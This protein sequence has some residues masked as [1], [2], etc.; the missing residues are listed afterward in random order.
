MLE[1]IEHTKQ[2]YAELGDDHAAIK[3]KVE[4]DKKLFVGQE[5]KGKKLGVIGLGHI[6]ASV[7]DA[8]IDLG[9]QV[10]GYDP[11]LSVEQAWR[12]PGHEITRCDTIEELLEQSDYVTIHS[13]YM[14][15]THHLLNEKRLKLM[16]PDSHIVNFAR[17]EL[18]DSSAMHSLYQAGKRTGRY[19]CDFP[20]ENL[21]G[22][23]RV[24]IIPHLG[25]STN[26]A[27]DNSAAMIAKQLMDFI[28]TGNVI[29]SVN[30]PQTKLDRPPKSGARICIVNKNVPGILGLITSTLGSANLNIQ[31]HI[32]TSKGEIAY[33]VIDVS[34]MPSVEDATALQSE[35][36]KLEGVVSSRI[37][38][39]SPEPRFFRVRG[40][41]F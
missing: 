25:A 31:Q 3:K 1:G 36:A 22:H 8:A 32:N 10:L 18:I 17:A 26:E 2:I 16:K 15:A 19:I 41:G 5:V 38:E 39:P 35:I 9:M 11:G 4:S 20:D 40:D 30:F 24:T 12:L 28:E 37:I 34:T 23:P 21:F 7:A 33:N 29:N 14:K 6:G 27:E 13:P